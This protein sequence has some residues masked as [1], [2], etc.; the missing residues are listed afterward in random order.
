MGIEF[1]ND[2]AFSF[3]TE[4]VF[5]AIDKNFGAGLIGHVKYYPNPD[6]GS[7]KIYVGILVGGFGLASDRF[8]G[9]GFEVGHKWVGERNILFEISGGIGKVFGVGE[10]VPYG[11]L[12]VG[13]RFSK[14]GNK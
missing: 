13:Y 3:E 5:F 7:D 11:R 12:M 6:F 10:V 8:A 1:P 2:Y 4:I 14:K 9:F